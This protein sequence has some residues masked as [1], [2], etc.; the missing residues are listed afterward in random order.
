MDFG[1]AGT[2]QLYWNGK[3]LSS[4]ID[5]LGYTI[6]NI[7]AGPATV[8]TVFDYDR[9]ATGISQS[10]KTHTDVTIP[11]SGQNDPRMTLPAGN[12]CAAA[13]ISSTPTASCQ[14]LPALTLNYQLNGLTNTNTSRS[15]IQ[16][17]LLNVGHLSYGG[18]GSRAFVTSAKVSV[19]FD[20]GATW[21]DVPA[22]GADGT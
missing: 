8:R 1:A 3:L 9:S 16:T 18:V 4:D 13:A 20:N 10:T 12:F 21:K 6:Q 15:P 17:L 7:P 22:F 5:R 11:Y 14:V 2:A 19:S